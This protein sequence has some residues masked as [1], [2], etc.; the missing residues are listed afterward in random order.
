MIKSPAFIKLSNASRV[1]YLLLK[2][3]CTKSGQR[4]IIFPYNDAEHYMK[5]ATF[6]RSIK[7]LIELGFIEKSS[8]GGLYRLTNVYRFTERWRQI[9][10]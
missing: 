3:Q 2:S 4:E 9:G 5:R 6:A 1:A 7:Q 10:K 8:F